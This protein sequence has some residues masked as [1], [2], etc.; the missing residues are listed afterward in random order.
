[1]DFRKLVDYRDG[2]VHASASRPETDSQP[3][4]EKPLPSKTDLDKLF[5]GWAVQVVVTLVKR[6]HDAVGT[7]PPDWLVYP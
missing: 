1:M 4:K 6:L 3:E 2:L 7:P 5:P